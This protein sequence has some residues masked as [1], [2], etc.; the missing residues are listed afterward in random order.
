MQLVLVSTWLDLGVAKQSRL[1]LQQ[2]LRKLLHCHYIDWTHKN[3][4]KPISLY[5]HKPLISILSFITLLE[6]VSLVLIFI[7]PLTF[8]PP[9]FQFLP[10]LIFVVLLVVLF[11]FFLLLIYWKLLFIIIRSLCLLI[12]LPYPVL[13][14]HVIKF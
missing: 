5:L 13:L 2:I 14:F 9:I 6:F 10:L 11:I 4:C 12:K 7:S 3:L 1:L 8:F